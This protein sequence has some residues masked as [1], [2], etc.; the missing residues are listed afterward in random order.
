MKFALMLLHHWS[1]G[2][3]LPSKTLT[4]GVLS[5]D[6]HSLDE[7]VKACTISMEKKN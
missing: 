5:G 3:G 4:N 1:M 7:M 2:L 6:T